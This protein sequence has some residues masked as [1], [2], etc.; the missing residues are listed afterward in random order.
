MPEHFNHTV[1][2]YVQNERQVRDALK[3]LS[4]T[5]SERNGIEHN[6]EYL[7][8]AEMADPSSHGVTSEGLDATERAHYVAD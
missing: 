5:Q 8:R 2:G 7:T 1:G 3:E 6:Y 4:D